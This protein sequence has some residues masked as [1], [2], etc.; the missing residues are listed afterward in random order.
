V[1]PVPATA[2]IRPN[3][4]VAPAPPRPE[5]PPLPEG[6]NAALPLEDSRVSLP[7]AYYVKGSKGGVAYIARDKTTKAFEYTDDTGASGPVDWM[8]KGGAVVMENAGGK[9]KGSAT[10]EVLSFDKSTW[11]R[12]A[13][14]GV[15]FDLAEQ[16]HE[17]VIADGRIN[18]RS[19]NEEGD[20]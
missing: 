5:T 2:P 12:I 6:E 8:P 19:V 15:Y 1:E 3:P 16:A 10:Q 11:H 17:I 13:L 4:P 7:G 18:V 14:L 9:V 20:V